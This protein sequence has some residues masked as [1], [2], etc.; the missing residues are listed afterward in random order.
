MYRFTN[1]PDR[2]FLYLFNNKSILFL[3]RKPLLLYSLLL[4]I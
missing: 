1:L 4:S 3:S 2:F